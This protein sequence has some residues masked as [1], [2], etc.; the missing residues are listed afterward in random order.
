[1]QDTIEVADFLNDKEFG[2]L[3][4]FTEKLISKKPLSSKNGT[5]GFP[6]QKSMV[7]KK[8]HGYMQSIQVLRLFQKLDIKPREKVQIMND[9]LKDIL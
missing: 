7:Q 2:I 3:K 9:A 1:M 5:I 4:M 6:Y 8:I